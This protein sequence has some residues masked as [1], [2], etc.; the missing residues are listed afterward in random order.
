MWK[1]SNINLEAETRRSTS[2]QLGDQGGE[3][4]EDGTEDGQ[5]ET[6]DNANRGHN[7]GERNRNCFNSQ[8]DL[9]EFFLDQIGSLAQAGRETL[10]D[11][12]TGAKA[13]SGARTVA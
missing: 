12:L 11:E 6:I 3:N 4:L 5:R 7:R 10:K 8:S 2:P 9:R 13:Q 1:K